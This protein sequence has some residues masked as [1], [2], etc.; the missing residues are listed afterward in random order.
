MLPNPHS[1]TLKTSA[2]STDSTA[3]EDNAE[4]APVAE[5]GASK[6]DDLE[7]DFRRRLRRAWGGGGGE[8]PAVNTLFCFGFHHQQL[9]VTDILIKRPL[10]CHSCMR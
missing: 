9:L 7:R 1:S 2:G 3:D 6:S 8:W 4:A 10:I 5:N